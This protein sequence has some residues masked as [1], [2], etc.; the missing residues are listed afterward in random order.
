MATTFASLMKNR[1][2]QA[3][4]LTKELNKLNSNSFEEDN[5]FWKPTRDKAG[6]G[7]AVIRF[8]PAPP[9][10]DVPWVRYWDHFFKGPTG[11]Y[12][13]NMSLTT[14]G[15]PDPVAEA[16]AKIWNSGKAGED[17]IRK[18]GRKRRLNYVSNIYV[19]NDPAKPENNGKVF[20]FKYGQKIFDKLNEKMNPTFEGEEKIIPFDFLEGCNFKLKVRNN[21]FGYPNY[22][23]SLFDP[24]TPLLDGDLE[25][26]EA[27]WKTEHSLQ[28]LVAPEKFKPYDVLAKELAG[29]LINSDYEFLGID[30]GPVAP[31]PVQRTAPARQAPVAE[32]DAAP[33][34][35]DDDDE[36]FFERI[37]G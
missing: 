26:L 3:D 31:A 22:D 29:V 30:A 7:Y 14:I 17:K 24:V 32:A 23:A 36:S 6:N 1:S 20:K 28:A 11:K 18:E 5:T 8:L 27:L 15:Q 10:E 19:I 33:F 13:V 9:G 2:K 16:N 34:V 4:L 12:Y 25:K 21:E 35:S 37:A